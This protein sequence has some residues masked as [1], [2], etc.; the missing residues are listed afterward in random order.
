MASD[1]I[2][3]VANLTQEQFD[4]LCRLAEETG[5]SRSAVIALSVMH[6]AELQDEKR[7][8]KAALK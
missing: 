5:F 7:A 4:T 2:R 6:Y 1:K 8:A 3:V